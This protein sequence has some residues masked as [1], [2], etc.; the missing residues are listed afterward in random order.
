MYELIAWFSA[1][2][3]AIC[4]YAVITL[5]GVPAFSSAVA[6]S[7][8]ASVILSCGIAISSLNDGFF[9]VWLLAIAF[10]TGAAT[11]CI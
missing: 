6:C 10:Q 5:S 4:W 7:L 1:S 9:S 11:C 3:G 2:S 8:S